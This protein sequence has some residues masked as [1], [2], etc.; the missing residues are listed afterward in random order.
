MEKTLAITGM[1]IFCWFFL[2]GFCLTNTWLIG[3]VPG[4]LL[5]GFGM[6]FWEK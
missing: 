4:L 1:V 5:S 2:C 3:C 6:M